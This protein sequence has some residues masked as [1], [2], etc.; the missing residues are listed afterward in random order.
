MLRYGDRG[1]VR[2]GKRLLAAGIPF[3]VT[4]T[5]ARAAVLSKRLSL[6]RDIQSHVGA[7]ATPK[8][9]AFPANAKGLV[10]VTLRLLPFMTI[11]WLGV[12]HGRKVNFVPGEADSIDVVF[13]CPEVNADVNPGGPERVH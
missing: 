12:S 11:F 10:P 4:V 5:G 2:Q 3:L 6:F 9:R 1:F 8:A 13:D 7:T